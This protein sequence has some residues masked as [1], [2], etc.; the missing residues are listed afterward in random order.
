MYRTRKRR[1]VRYR[2]RVVLATLPLASTGH[3]SLPAEQKHTFD[4]APAESVERQPTSYKP[5]YIPCDNIPVLITQNLTPS[6]FEPKPG[7]PTPYLKDCAAPIEPTKYLDDVNAHERDQRLVFVGEGELHEYFLDGQTG[8]TLSVTSLVKTFFPEFDTEAV[9]ER[10]F[11][12]KTFATRNHQPSYRYAGC[13]S[14]QDIKDRWSKWSDLGTRLHLNIEQY[15]NQIAV[16]PCEENL[17][18]WRQFQRLMEDSTF[19]RWEPYR[20]EWGV[21]DEETLICGQIDFC[22]MINP[23]TKEVV[24]IDWKRCRDIPRFA[25]PS[26]ETGNKETGYGCCM[27]LD[28]CKYFKY[29]LQLNVYKYILE[30][31][32]GLR[33]SQMLLVQFHPSLENNNGAKVMLVPNLQDTVCRM[34]YCRLHALKA[35]GIRE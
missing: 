4:A 19:V 27:K 9:A 3:R 15:Y 23:A 30:K 18:T 13:K 29:S 14:V 33:V 8:L 31:N 25:Y 1:E 24:L 16:E 10:T 22:G 7:L 26:R 5:L 20:T 34:M 28:S 21:F 12:S 6:P 32:Y 17:C 11:N 35:A 2:P